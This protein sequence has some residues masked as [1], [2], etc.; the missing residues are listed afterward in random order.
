MVTV[1]EPLLREQLLDRRQRL[2]VA[3]IGDRNDDELTRLLREVDT[4][5]QRMDD[6]T[7]GI[8]D[9]CNEPVETGRLIADPL[10]RLCI[11]HLSPNEQ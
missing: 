9:V 8:C 2:E 10:T 5:L 7:Y 1:I 4:A 11:D 6:G 3:T